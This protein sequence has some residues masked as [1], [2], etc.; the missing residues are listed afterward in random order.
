MRLWAVLLFLPALGGCGGTTSTPKGDGSQ[1]DTTGGAVAGGDE[2]PDN[3]APGER[4]WPRAHTSDVAALAFSPDGK[5]LASA[6]WDRTIKLWD[7]PAGKVRH[8]LK[9]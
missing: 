3:K 1:E 9:G 4:E 2:S 6:S 5:T 7:F 8:T